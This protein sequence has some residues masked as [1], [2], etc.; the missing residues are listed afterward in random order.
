MLKMALPEEACIHIPKKFY[1]P[2]G[3]NYNY[4]RKVLKSAWHPTQNIVAIACLNSLF[5]YSAN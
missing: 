3:Q 5:L 1:E 4:A 2:L